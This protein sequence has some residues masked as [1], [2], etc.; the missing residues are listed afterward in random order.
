M[1]NAKGNLS[2]TFVK[3]LGFF[4]AVAVALLLWQ[5]DKSH[6]YLGPWFTLG[7]NFHLLEKNKGRFC[8]NTLLSELSGSEKAPSRGASSSAGTATPRILQRGKFLCGAHLNTHMVTL[9]NYIKHFPPASSYTIRAL[10]GVE[11]WGKGHSFR[12]NHQPGKSP[13]DEAVCSS[14]RPVQNSPSER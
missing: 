13:L 2:C 7:F 10:E 8:R 6:F 12:R 3:C 1:L 11:G 4:C 9:K 5:A 14:R